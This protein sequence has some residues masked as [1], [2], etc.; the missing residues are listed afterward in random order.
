MGHV[1]HDV[2]THIEETPSLLTQPGVK[3]SEE[4]P[5]ELGHNLKAQ[6]LPL[7]D[8]VRHQIELAENE[9]IPSQGSKEG[10]EGFENVN[11]KKDKSTCEPLP[12]VSF[13]EELATSSSPNKPSQQRSKKRKRK[14]KKKE[15]KERKRAKREMQRREQQPKKQPMASAGHDSKVV[16]ED[17]NKENQEREVAPM[18]KN[19]QCQTTEGRY[20][21]MSKVDNEIQRVRSSLLQKKQESLPNTFLRRLVSSRSTPSIPSFNKQGTYREP[22]NS[23]KQVPK[24]MDSLILQP[25]LGDLTSRT[26]VKTHMAPSQSGLQPH[27]STHETNI[28][29]SAVQNPLE[30]R[31]V[32]PVKVPETRA[33]DTVLTPGLRESDLNARHPSKSSLSKYSGRQDPDRRGGDTAQTTRQTTENHNVG[34]A[35][36]ERDPVLSSGGQE[37][38]LVAPTCLHNRFSTQLKVS[39]AGQNQPGLPGLMSRP[40]TQAMEPLSNKRSASID[41]S[42][43][44]PELGVHMSKAPSQ[45]PNTKTSVP[46]QTVVQSQR[47]PWPPIQ[48]SYE[49]HAT[50]LCKSDSCTEQQGQGYH[51]EPVSELTEPK[52]SPVEGKSRNLGAARKP[53]V[54]AL[55]QSFQDSGFGYQETPGQTD[56]EDIA[57]VPSI[58]LLCSEAFLERWGQAV[59]MLSSGKWCNASQIT[60]EVSGAEQIFAIGRKI[61]V[62]DS[63]LVD[64][65]NVDL[66][67]PGRCAVLV[68]ATSSF[69]VNENAK[70]FVLRTTTLYALSRYRHLYVILVLDTA[71]TPA[72]AHRIFQL[73]SSIV[74][75]SS[76]E[77]TQLHFKTTLSQSLAGS[78]AELVTGLGADM[79]D[80]D[81]LLKHL[82]NDQDIER[83]LFLLSLLPTMCVYGALQTLHL[84]EAYS[85]ERSINTT[86]GLLFSDKQLRQRI[87]FVA[88][89][90]KAGNVHPQAMMQLC[91]FL[92]APLQSSMMM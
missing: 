64:N 4:R 77:S 13:Q 26:E 90:T 49:N 73:Q 36:S 83:A 75:Y 59:A 60:S 86:F 61:M 31:P 35:V 76:N 23:I 47:E 87:M 18:H 55:Q 56:F 63:P 51:E 28:G 20:A 1:M 88:T 38:P 84:A 5:G 54:A 9:P 81:G 33:L 82:Q 50:A 24:E 41:R 85:K 15:H 25:R 40:S 79:Q 16:V 44:E 91:E 89:S 39:A 43:K 29:T 11:T 92:R 32:N 14:E 37:R 71:T 80:T 3:T 21:L 17:S 68:V 6:N 74:S 12:R 34:R 2:Q 46:P 27:K 58:R 52:L 57:T 69:L 7:G 19:V 10:L 8:H 66:E 45:P 78:I 30:A 53:S 70:R 22:L 62:Q 42:I 48:Q 65:C 72:I 67:L